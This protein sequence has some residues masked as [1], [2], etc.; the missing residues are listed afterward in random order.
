[1][2]ELSITTES[3]LA[4]V[5]AGIQAKGQ[6]ID[7]HLPAIAEMLVSAVHDVLEAEG[8][9]W[10]ELADSTKRQRR[11]SSYKILQDTGLF[12]SSI[13]GSYGSTYAEAVD[14]TTYGHYHV[15]GTKRMPKRDWT[16]LGPYEA[17]LLEDVAELLVG[18][19]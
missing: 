6:S 19:F 18:P 11:G 10:Q 1:V 16:E 14:G 7:R 8:P 3:D 12:A 17:G 5:L 13:A 4:K 9:G 2:A 15:T